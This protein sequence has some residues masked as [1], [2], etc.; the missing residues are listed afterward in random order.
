MSHV[1]GFAAAGAA[2]WRRLGR[3]TGEG[4]ADPADVALSDPT[5]GLADS[6]R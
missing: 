2:P 6:P 1:V 5:V 3:L 4:F